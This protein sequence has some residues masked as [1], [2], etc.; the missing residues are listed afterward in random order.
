MTIAEE[1]LADVS[2]AI[3]WSFAAAVMLLGYS[4][5]ALWA[6]IVTSVIVGGVTTAGFVEARFT[7]GQLAERV[8]RQANTKV[9]IVSR[10]PQ[11]WV[12]VTLP[13]H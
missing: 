12:A 2:V 9:W 11:L 10:T 8:E 6:N 13:S 3:T 1:Q 5:K 7:L 4:A